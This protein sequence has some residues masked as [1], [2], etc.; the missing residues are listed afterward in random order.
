MS[1]RTCGWSGN[2]GHSRCIPH[3]TS[4]AWLEAQTPRGGSISTSSTRNPLP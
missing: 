4:C 2:R 3:A 1:W